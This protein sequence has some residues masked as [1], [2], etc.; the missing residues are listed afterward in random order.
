M[1]FGMGFDMFGI[2]FTIVF[3]LVIGTFITTAARGIGQWNKNNNSPRLTVPADVVAKRTNV[4]RHR[5]NG[6]NGHHHHH[7]S[8]TYYVTFQVESGDRMELEM[9][10]SEYGLLIEGDHGDLTFQGTR[11]LGFERL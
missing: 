1:G 4:T 6:A 11:Y 3:V 5:H 9:T 7:T 2:M 8:T 10:G